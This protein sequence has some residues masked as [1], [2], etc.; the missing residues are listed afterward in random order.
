MRLCRGRFARCT[1]LQHH[2]NAVQDWVV[3]TTTGAVQPCVESIVWTGG[4]GLMAYRAHQNA[5]QS[6][7]KNRAR[8]AESL[9]Q[10]RKYC[11]LDKDSE[12]WFSLGENHGEAYRFGLRHSRNCYPSLEL[13]HLP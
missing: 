10:F 1:L 7:G 3:A 5:E 12:V 8:H 13:A 4:D 11:G 2:G 6:L 9:D